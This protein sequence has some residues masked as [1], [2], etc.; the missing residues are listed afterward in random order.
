[1]DKFYRQAQ[2][3]VGLVNAAQRGN[4]ALVRW[5]LGS[6]VSER[7]TVDGRSGIFK[8][9]VAA[10][11]NG[12]L[13]ILEQVLVHDKR[14]VC[15][16]PA[17]ISAARGNKLCPSPASCMYHHAYAPIALLE[18]IPFR[19]LRPNREAHQSMTLCQPEF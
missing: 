8:A 7:F 3:S 18:D 11:T 9:A 10:A 13:R 4:T 15:I 6:I 2:L 5:V 19:P 14:G 12:H 16:K 17:M 1:M